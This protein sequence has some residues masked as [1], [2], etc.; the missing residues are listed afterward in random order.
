MDDSWPLA[1]EGLRLTSPTRAVRATAAGTAVAQTAAAARAV[2]SGVGA[3]GSSERGRDY[4]R[5]TAPAIH[6]LV[7]IPLAAYAPVALTI[8]YAAAS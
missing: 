3:G 5:V 2:A 8:W 1:A 6:C 7:A 4:F